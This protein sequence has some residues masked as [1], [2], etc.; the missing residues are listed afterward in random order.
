MSVCLTCNLY[1]SDFRYVRI[2]YEIK[3]IW[4]IF[5]YCFY[6]LFCGFYN[7]LWRQWVNIWSILFKYYDEDEVHTALTEGKQIFLNIKNSFQQK[8]DQDFF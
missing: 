7:H 8:M 1:N 6:Y 2:L 3:G 4:R 5:L